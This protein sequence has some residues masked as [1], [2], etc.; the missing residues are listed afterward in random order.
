MRRVAVVADSSA[1]L[2]AELLAEHGI[3]IV[4]LVFLF[5]GQLYRDGDFP[6]HEFYRRLQAARGPVR[7]ASAAPGEFVEAFRRAREEGARAVLCLTLSS[8]YSGTY[9][10]AR[11]AREIAGQEMPDLQVQVMD[12]QGIAMTH[13]LA[14]L[15]AARAVSAGAGLTDAMTAAQSVGSRSHLIGALDTMR[16]LAKSGRVPWIVHWA[17]SLLQIKPVLAAEAGAIHSVARTRTM[18]RALER[19]LAYMAARVD[20]ALSLHV[21]VMHADAPDRGRHLAERIRERFSP[22]ELLMTEVTSV[23]G[24]HSGPGFVGAAFYCGEE[25]SPRPRRRPLAERDADVLERALGD[26]PAP[27]APAALVVLSGLPG[28]GKS[29]FRRRLVARYP[30]AALESDALRGALFPRPTHAEVENK[31]LFP[32]IHVLLDRLLTRGVPVVLDATNLKEA[33]RRVLYRIAEKHGAKLVLV[34]LTAPRRVARRRLA[35]RARGTDPSD[36]S[37]AGPPVYERMLAEVEP[38]ERPHFVVDTSGEISDA[39]EEIVR[40]LEGGPG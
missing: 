40:E 24:V 16:F 14:V 17:A 4:P 33:N 27:T 26:L 10:A 21:A 12:T 38:I 28:T 7:T 18:P 37:E 35:A 25:L 13:G 3:I 9:S 2:P 11:H 30:L 5:D 32:A 22:R 1:C 19:V 15:A 36:A 29:H 20:P 23:M 8:R 6:P 31:R 34:Q 39:L